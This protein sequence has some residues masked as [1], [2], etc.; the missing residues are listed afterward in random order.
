MTRHFSVMDAVELTQILRAAGRSE[1]MPRFRR[2]GGDDVRTKTG[3]SDLVT[4]A[5]EAAERLIMQ[6]LQR[7][8]PGCVVIG[9]EAAS[10]NPMLLDQLMEAELA[11]VVDPIDGTSNFA[12][13]VP[14]FGMMTAVLA[15]GEVV[16]SVIHDPVCD[17]AAV[18]VRGEGAWLEHPDVRRWHCGSPRQPARRR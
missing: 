2:L 5:D 12:A 8:F 9:E 10:G 15:R 16:A 18:A 17:G 11:F 7:R 6:G 13:G 4:V 3:P 1:V 14:L